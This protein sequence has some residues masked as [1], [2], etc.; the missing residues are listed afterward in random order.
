MRNALDYVSGISF[1][2]AKD[3][4]DPPT[5]T[6]LGIMLDV[7][8]EGCQLAVASG[9]RRF[10]VVGQRNFGTRELAVAQVMVA[11]CILLDAYS[12][13]AVAWHVAEVGDVVG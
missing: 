9:I 5:C 10:S 3:K 6:G 1:L 2:Q 11:A 8:V 12:G 4:L 13:F 7:S